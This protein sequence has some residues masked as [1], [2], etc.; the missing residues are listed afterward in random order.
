MGQLNPSGWRERQLDH[1]GSR[2]PPSC[3]H[4]CVDAK[5]AVEGYK[6]GDGVASLA[7]GKYYPTSRMERGLRQGSQLKVL[8]M[9]QVGRAGYIICRAQYKMQM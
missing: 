2:L 9:R 8:K 3:A 6:A 5:G 1:T 4:H 7:F